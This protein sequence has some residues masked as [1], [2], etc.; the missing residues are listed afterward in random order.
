MYIYM[1]VYNMYELC[2]IWSVNG[3]LRT[4]LYIYTYTHT[5]IY[6]YI[7]ICIHVYIYIYMSA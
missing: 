1:Y 6:I 3:L 7:Y 4:D 5:H 2:V